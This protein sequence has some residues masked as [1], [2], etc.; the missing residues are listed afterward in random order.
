M[1]QGKELMQL[2]EQLYCNA[3]GY[4]HIHNFNHD[5][6]AFDYIQLL[7]HIGEIQGVPPQV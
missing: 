2:T 3:A 1:I 5:P 6:Q 7:Q 4:I